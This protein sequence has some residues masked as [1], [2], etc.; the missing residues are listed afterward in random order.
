[1]SFYLLN[2]VIGCYWIDL[3]DVADVRLPGMPLVPYR[4]YHHV[5]LFLVYFFHFPI[6]IFCAVFS[7]L[8]SHTEKKKVTNFACLVS[9]L[10]CKSCAFISKTLMLKKQNT[11]ALSYPRDWN[12]YEPFEWMLPLL[13]Q[14]FFYFCVDILKTLFLFLCRYFKDVSFLTFSVTFIVCEV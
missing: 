14:P 3:F 8:S 1:M 10:P 12:I 2:I 5:L 7:S 9:E 13:M 6:F 4:L 11:S